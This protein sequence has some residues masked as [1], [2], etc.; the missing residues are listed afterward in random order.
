MSEVT[1]LKMN[2]FAQNWWQWLDSRPRR[3]PK[4]KRMLSRFE[5]PKEPH[6]SNSKTDARKVN[7]CLP[8]EKAK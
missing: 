6:L 4:R 3:T 8:K 5:T 2:P 7:N 1:S